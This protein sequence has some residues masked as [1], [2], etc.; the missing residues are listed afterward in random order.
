MPADQWYLP[1]SEAGYHPDGSRPIL[2][3]CSWWIRSGMQWDPNEPARSE[4]AGPVDSAEQHLC[5]ALNLMW[6]DVFPLALN[7]GMK[8][9]LDQQ[10]QMGSR[11]SSAW[12]ARSSQ[13]GRARSGF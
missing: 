9:A 10:R 5:W 12:V 6:E 4:L 3:A 11:L 8:W 2:R 13:P 7:P 1:V